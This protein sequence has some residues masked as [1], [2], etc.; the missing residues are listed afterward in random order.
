MKTEALK[1]CP[2]CGGTAKILDISQRINGYSNGGMWKY[3]S[4]QTCG[5][6]THDFYWDD[7]EEM[8]R[9]WNRRVSA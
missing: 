6:R 8:I 7:R 2:F 5:C 1:N 9:T 4:C 3:V